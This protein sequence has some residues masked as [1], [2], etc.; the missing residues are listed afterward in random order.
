[1][2]PT[3][4]EIMALAGLD[5]ACRAHADS[6]RLLEELEA[7]AIALR[8]CIEDA[9]RN[10]AAWSARAQRFARYVAQVRDKTSGSGARTPV[11]YTTPA[12]GP[13]EA[14]T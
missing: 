14:G 2:T 12:G 1:M 4:L 8:V 13:E 7:E 5:V 10:E 3:A 9:K 11:T 6:V